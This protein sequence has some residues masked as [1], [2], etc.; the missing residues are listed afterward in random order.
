MRATA[1]TPGK[2]VYE[3]A[4]TAA[5]PIVTALRIEALPTTGETARHNPEDGFIVDQIEAWVIQ[6][7][8][9]QEKIRIH[10]FVS[11]S[12]DDHKGAVTLRIKFG[13]SVG[14]A[15]GCAANG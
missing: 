11:D 6:P 5:V 7:N 4:A 2:S 1:T 10:N 8:G 3:V 9:H 15:G 12:E 14:L 13:P